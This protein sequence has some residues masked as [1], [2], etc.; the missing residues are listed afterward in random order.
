MILNRKPL[1]LAQVKEYSKELDSSLP[2][3][4]YL[5]SFSNLSIK[6]AEKLSQEIAD[7]NNPKIKEEHITKVVDL[8]PRDSEDLNKIFNEVSLS[9][10]EAKTLLEIT[11]NY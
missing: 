11:K 6:D 10:D 2:I 7:L 4:E 9:E 8:L 5:K 3:I 1:N